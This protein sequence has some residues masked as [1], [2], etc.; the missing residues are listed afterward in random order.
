MTAPPSAL[1]RQSAFCG[2]LAERG[3]RPEPQ[4]QQED[5]MPKGQE[6]TDKSNKPKLTTKEKQQKKKEKQASKSGS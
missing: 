6:K 2:G 3:Q 5:T 1:A 4:R